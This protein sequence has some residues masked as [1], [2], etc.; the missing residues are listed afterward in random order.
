MERLL[1]LAAVG[2]PDRTP[3]LIAGLRHADWRVR[4]LAADLIGRSGCKA[5]SAAL[6]ALLAGETP[7]RLYG[8][9]RLIKWQ[10]AI[11]QWEDPADP[12]RGDVPDERDRRQRVKTAVIEALGRLRAVR[13]V[14]ALCRILKD[15]REFYPVHSLACKALGLIGD[16]AALPTLKKAA[17]YSEA[18]TRSRARD[19]IS[20]LTTGQPRSPD[21]PDR[22]A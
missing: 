3:A 14:P 5:A 13:A 21:Y 8:I 19:A 20:R 15:Q 22:A 11:E 10:D 17:L 7:D 2:K 4:M 12:D 16:P 9:D 18:N 6:L 1:A